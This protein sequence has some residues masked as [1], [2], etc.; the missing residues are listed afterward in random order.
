M[1]KH[2]EG[3]E[4]EDL[5][6]SHSDRS[7]PK[8][9]RDNDRL[10]QAKATDGRST[11][12]VENAKHK[13]LNAKFQGEIGEGLTERAAVDKLGLTPDPRF[14]AAKH[15]FDT[16]YKDQQG[17]LVVIE[18]KFDDRGIKALNGDQ[19]QPEWVARNARMMQNPGNERFTEG[20]AAI[21]KE[22]QKT[23]ADSI[24][25]IVI[26]TNPRTLETS[27]YEGQADGSWKQIGQ[28][29]ALEFE[30]PYLH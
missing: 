5:R 2:L 14:D 17:G 18:S 29:S 10:E 30:Q 13:N 12:A 6:E 22:I 3:S 23:G 19:M 28:W 24:R 26:A 20:N 7:I 1:M 9:F 27:A 15:G 25:R 21:G 4:Q 8:R 11:E 16:V